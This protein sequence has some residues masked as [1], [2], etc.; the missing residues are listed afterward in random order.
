MCTLHT[1]SWI[2]NSQHYYV[3]CLVHCLRSF[4]EGNGELLL[5]HGFAV[6]GNP[7]D[8]VSSDIWRVAPT[9]TLILILTHTIWQ[10]APTLTLIL[11]LTRTIW[12]GATLGQ[13]D[14]VVFGSF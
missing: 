1:Q 8:M 14:H 2:D 13:C 6:S 9:L 11:I 5:G 10:V 12:W 7:Y 3:H 4:A